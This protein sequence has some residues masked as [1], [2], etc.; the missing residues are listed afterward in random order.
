MIGAIIGDIAG[1]IY[2]FDNHRSKEFSLFGDKCFFTDDTVM[3][4]AVGKAIKQFKDG[5][6]A[7]LPK[8]AIESMQKLGRPY[9]R[10]GYG[11]RFWSWIYTDNPRPY[12]SYGNGAAMR[13]SAAGFAAESEEEAKRLSKAVT[14]VSHNHPEGI[15]GAEA[16]ALAIF[17]AKSGVDKKIIGSRINE[18]YYKLNFTLDG[19]RETYLFNETCQDTVPQAIQ[20]FLESVD[21]EDA[22]RCAISVGG[23]SD[24]LAA[25]TGGIAEAYYGVPISLERKAL[26]YLD[27]NLRAAYFECKQFNKIIC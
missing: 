11:G 7:D 24:T 19:I 17:W 23:D 10:C 20:A 22:I 21:F 9:P 12:N 15:K 8:A 26:T 16:V 6:A 5:N 18:M 14:E 27:D 4:L 2:E 1:S 3:T 25:I 13:I